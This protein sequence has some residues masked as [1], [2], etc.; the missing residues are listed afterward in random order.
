[1]ITAIDTSVLV[2][3]LWASPSYGRESLAAVTRA[4]REGRLV[5]CEVVF[6]E[7]AGQFGS[8]ERLDEVLSGVDVAFDA[9]G[10][11]AA[12][13]AGLLWREYRRR[14]GPRERMVADFLIGAHA[15]HQA[16][17]LLSRDRGFHRSYLPDLKLMVPGGA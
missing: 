3:I 11:A 5:V 15:V 16:D 13:T 9:M 7:L 14:G 1:M 6:A 10:E 4:S 12:A 2:D 8:A 17:R